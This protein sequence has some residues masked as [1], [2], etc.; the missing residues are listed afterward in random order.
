MLSERKSG[1]GRLRNW[2]SETQIPW[3]SGLT[4]LDL[5]VKC[6]KHSILILLQE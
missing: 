5:P 4:C 2:Q 1:L 6:S 3:P